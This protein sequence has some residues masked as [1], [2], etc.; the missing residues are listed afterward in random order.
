[1]PGHFEL[2]DGGTLF[3][4]EI[5]DMP[6]EIQVKLLRLLQD[7]TVKRLGGTDELQVNVRVVAATNKDLAKEVAAEHFR[8]DLYYRL[9]VITVY[10]PPLRQR[11]QDIPLLAAHFLQKYALE[12]HKEV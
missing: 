4:D 8:Q 11:R 12:N 10:L 6:V 3:L 9:N 5:G 1:K 7:G 2:A